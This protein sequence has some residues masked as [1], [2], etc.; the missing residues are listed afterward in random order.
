[1]KRILSFILTALILLSVAGC[2]KSKAPA[3][4]VSGKFCVLGVDGEKTYPERTALNF[5]FENGK[6]DFGQPTS[7]SSWIRRGGLTVEGSRI[8]AVCDRQKTA[9]EDGELKM[10]GNYTW[11]FELEAD[12]RLRFIEEGSDT[13]DVYGTQLNKDSILVRIGDPDAD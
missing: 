2:A 11:I 9:F 1:M 8:T 12:G 5:D 10:L 7:D 4:P 3:E 13:F 6:F